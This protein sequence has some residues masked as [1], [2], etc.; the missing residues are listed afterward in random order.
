MRANSPIVNTTSFPFI[1][2]IIEPVVEPIVPPMVPPMVE[3]IK[4]GM[5]L[6]GED[7]L[8]SER[9]LSG[10]V[11]YFN[12]QYIPHEI[13]PALALTI[14]AES[15]LPSHKEDGFSIASEEQG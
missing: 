5:F 4:L 15:A 12:M 6:K 7:N 10:I 11:P 2:P 9:Y 8:M 3:P 1:T 14:I 13:V